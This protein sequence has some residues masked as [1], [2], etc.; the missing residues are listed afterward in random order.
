MSAA[1][2]NGKNI[3]LI[4]YSPQHFVADCFLEIST[5]GFIKVNYRYETIDSYK[6]H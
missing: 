3:K 6:K 5:F 2:E 4:K 1:P